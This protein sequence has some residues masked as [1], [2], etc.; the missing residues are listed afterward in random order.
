ML[1]GACGGCGLWEPNDATWNWWNNGAFYLMAHVVYK[2][3]IV[4]N[5]SSYKF[6]EIA[7][8]ET[9]W[10]ICHTFRQPRDAPRRD[11]AVIKS[12]YLI[13]MMIKQIKQAP[14]RTAPARLDAYCVNMG[15]SHL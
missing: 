11:L 6:H 1:G 5:Y 8:D 7:R 4:Q 2:R 14:A 13:K 15:K 9:W 10:V 3:V 12:R